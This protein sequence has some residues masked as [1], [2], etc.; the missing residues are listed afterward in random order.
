MGRTDNTT[1]KM[2]ATVSR[3][4]KAACLAWYVLLAGTF[5]ITINPSHSRASK[6]RC[7]GQRPCK[8]VKLSIALYTHLC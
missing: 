5:G 7:D 8:P 1:K 2:D 4:V 3:P 6:T